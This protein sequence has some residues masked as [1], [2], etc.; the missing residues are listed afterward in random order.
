MDYCKYHPVD[1]ATFVCRQCN[2]FLCDHCVDDEKDQPRCF[3]CGALL[4]N[5]GSANKVEPFW[6][7]LSEAFKYPLNSA[8]MSLIVITSIMMLIAAL[9]PYLFFIAIPLFLIAMG[10]LMKYALTCLE[11]TS[12][13]E[14]QAPDVMDAYHGT[15]KIIFQ[16]IL[17]FIVLGALPIGAYILSPALGGI[18]GLLTIIAMPAI[19]IRFAQSESVFEA[20][21]PVSVFS[22]ITAIGL[23]YGL[24]LAFLLIMS[25]SV[26]VLQGL[27]G[28]LFP[29]V[30]YLLQI[31]I[32][33]YY[34]LVMFHLM[35]YML[36]Q[37][38][39]QLG[40]S[41]RSDEEDHLSQRNDAERLT[42][43]ISVFLKEGNYEKV[44]DL[45]YQAFKL[46]P[47]EAIFFD[48]FFDLVYSCKKAALMEDFGLIYL[49]FLNRKKRFDKL[50]ICFKQIL[51]LVP[52]YLP[53]SPDMRV[54]LAGLLKQ[55]GDLKL[56]VKLLNGMHK[57]YPDFGKLPEAYTLLADILM[58]LPNMQAQS[59]KCRQM[60]EQLKIKAV[61]KQQ[62]LAVAQ[63]E[64]KNAEQKNTATTPTAAPSKRRGPPPGVKSSGL[65]LELLPI[66]PPKSE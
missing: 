58:E 59:V 55:Q 51:H 18:I 19:L 11:R 36:F 31:L 53:D 14:M 25:S 3:S 44:V 40:Y 10:A 35:G 66:E 49:Q 37:Y 38:Q 16:L 41:A 32:S 29:A 13:G 43:K 2:T 20:L 57:L 17:I 8:A 60:V 4:E 26:S 22:L 1:G 27:I 45:Y 15:I 7:R 42:A 39:S 21:N 23:P 30:S 47:N 64:K 54:Q 9:I 50:T 5:L 62:A 33:N 65:V 52:D 12:H 46:F 56:A 34:T 63:E 28:S 24:I 48:K 61:E 6:R